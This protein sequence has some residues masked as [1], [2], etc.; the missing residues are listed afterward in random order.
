M[1]DL[2]EQAIEQLRDLPEEEQNAAAD[3]LFAY[4]SS[5]ERQYRLRSDQI[6]Q[7]RRIQRDL[8]DG[9]T[10]LA[11]EAEVSAVKKKAGL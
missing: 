7:A 9:N 6:T 3:V 8:H 4:V 10:R 1:T 11:T 2:L 5:D